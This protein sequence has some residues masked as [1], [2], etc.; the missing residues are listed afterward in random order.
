[1]PYIWVSESVDTKLMN[2]Y[3]IE[4]RSMLT[5][6]DGPQELGILQ[7]CEELDRDADLYSAVW[8][9]LDRWMRSRI[10]DIRDRF[11]GPKNPITD[12]SIQF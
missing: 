4:L 3:V 5:H 10:K 6:P 8:A 7:L 1:M 2:K 11:P 12:D 9:H